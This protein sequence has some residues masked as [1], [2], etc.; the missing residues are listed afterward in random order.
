[1][2]K[3]IVRLIFALVAIGSMPCF[4]VYYTDNKKRHYAT[5]KAASWWYRPTAYYGYGIYEYPY[6]LPQDSQNKTFWEFVNQTDYIVTVYSGGKTFSIYPR[7]SGKVP[8]L[9]SF[10]FTITTKRGDTITYT[11]SNHLIKI[12]EDQNTD[13]IY[14]TTKS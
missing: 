5:R 10:S 3:K 12:K 9:K 13:G 11:T 8:H 6:Q 2:N 4:A 1:M 14:I 7:S